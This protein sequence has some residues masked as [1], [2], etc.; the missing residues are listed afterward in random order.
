MVQSNDHLYVLL[1]TTNVRWSTFLFEFCINC[2]HFHSS[3]NIYCSGRTILMSRCI[4]KKWWDF[5]LFGIS[6]KK[7]KVYSQSSQEMPSNHFL[8][9]HH[10]IRR[11][12]GNWSKYSMSLKDREQHNNFLLHRC[13]LYNVARRKDNAYPFQGLGF[14]GLHNSSTTCFSAS[15]AR[16]FSFSNSM[17]EEWH[18]RFADCCMFPLVCQIQYSDVTLPNSNLLTSPS[19][20]NPDWRWPFMVVFVKW[21]VE[22]HN[23][24]H[25]KGF[26]FFF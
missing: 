15:P 10:S 1:L 11:S 8:R 4:K 6:N 21:Y 16:D 14:K 5:L 26:F 12:V 25:K 18:S 22:A 7:W 23:W 13:F 2:V 3:V 19:L 20:S 9:F 17:R 24:K